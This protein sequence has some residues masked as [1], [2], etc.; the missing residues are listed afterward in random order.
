MDF[1]GNSMNISKPSFQCN[2]VCNKLTD[3]IVFFLPTCYIH[4]SLLENTTLP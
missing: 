1:P 3:E 2:D 4:L